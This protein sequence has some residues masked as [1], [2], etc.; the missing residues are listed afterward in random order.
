[1]KKI[2]FTATVMNHI[3]NFH[4]P[5]LKWFFK[6]NYEVHIACSEPKKLNCVNKIHDISI[7]RSPY[8]FTNI[9]AFFKLKK[10]INENE[11]NIIHSHTP[12]GGALTRIAA[13]NARKEGTKVIYT[14]HGFH[15]FKGAPIK[16]WI[17][18][19]PVEKILSSLTDVLITINKE[20]YELALSSF[21]ANK[22]KLIDGVGVDL[23][24]FY[25]VNSIKK[26]DLRKKY[27]YDK[28]DF[29][30]IYVAELSHRKNQ[31]M[32]IQVINKLVNKIPNLKLLLV[33]KGNLEDKYKKKIRKNHL[34]NY[35]DLLGYRKDIPN[36]MRI[37]DIAV[38]T[39]LQEGLPVNIM[40]AMAT[41]LPLVVT[42]C[43]GNRDLVIDG[44]NGYTSK[45]NDIEIFTKNIEDLYINEQK[46][47]EYGENSYK[48]IRKYSLKRVKKDYIDLYKKLINN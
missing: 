13:I 37:S 17:L 42:N 27:S 36:L 6:N 29:I 7:S 25:P 46:R 48:M 33:G 40:E 26:N 8:K 14:A 15:F 20:D 32:I 24:D 16:N 10:I 34:D 19:Y 2:L 21:L 47:C 9:K 30:L 35:I 43:R 18:Y 23:S 3:E 31:G 12:M 41:S 45:I 39:S 1:M 22:I 44:Q 4:L 5:Y 11:Y 38:S 28:N